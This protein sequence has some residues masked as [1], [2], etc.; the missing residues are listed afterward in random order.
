MIQPGIDESS[1]IRNTRYQVCIRNVALHAQ[2][3]TSIYSITKRLLEESILNSN[4]WKLSLAIAF[5]ARSCV[6]SQDGGH[7][8]EIKPAVDD[9]LPEKSKCANSNQ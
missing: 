4:T 3:V 8:D 9:T 7:D 1:A 5:G 2:T 6:P